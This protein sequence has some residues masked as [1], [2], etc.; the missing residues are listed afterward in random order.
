MEPLLLDQAN[1]EIRV[2]FGMAEAEFAQRAQWRASAEVFRA[3]DATLREAA[4]HPEVFV[5]AAMLRG[6][7]VEFAER[8]AAAD[9]AVRLNLAES[10]VRAHGTVASTLRQRLPELWAWFTEG[11]ISTQNAREAAAIAIELPADCWAAFERQTLDAARTLA[12]ARFRTRARAVRE[13]LHADTLTQRHAAAQLQRGV[14]TE[15]DR[16]GMGWLHARLSSEHLTMVSAHLDGIAFDLFT[17]ADEQRT[18]AQLRADALVDLLTGTGEQKPGVT[19]ALTVP[20]LSLLGQSNEPALLEGVGPIDLDTARRLCATA[21]SITR[22]LT[23]PV[24]GTVLQMDPHQYRSSA[25]LKRWLA[26]Q[27]VTCDFPGCGRRAANCDLDHTVAWADGGATTADNLS[28]RCRKH[29]T[30]KHQTAWRVERPP[31]SER[32]VWTSPTG[33][34]READPPPF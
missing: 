15:V 5:D 28:H 23:D 6:D 4:A 17:A 14:W 18:M 32:A 16:D 20:V 26:I 9:L 10:T 24:T 1:A 11:E 7:A 27:Q 25:A 33:Y 19:V 13:K 8:A 12:P 34:R 3:I 31:G 29:H 30:M 2:E 22:L 21:P